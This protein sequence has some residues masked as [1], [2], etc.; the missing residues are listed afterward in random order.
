MSALLAVVRRDLLLAYRR[1]S[2]L[3]NP[4]VFFV[5][6]ITLFPL[7]VSPAPNT[8]SQM[9]PGVIWISALLATLL[10][11]ESLFRS[12]FDDGS[13]ELLLLTETPLPLIVM[14]KI[15]SHW[16]VSSLPLIILAPALSQL[17]YM[18]VEALGVLMLSLLLG[19]P[20][21]SLLGAVGVA[22]TVGLKRGG[23]LV[24]LL[25]LPLYIPILI[26]AVGAVQSATMGMD[27]GFQL[28]L[29]GAMFALAL[30]LSPFATAAALRISLS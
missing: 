17:L 30:T 13:L 8:L 12:D 10:S 11:L 19:T 26:F 18:P 1:R 16:L 3:M 7:A 25:V 20:I 2:E 5:I 29:L 14:G 27:S 28:Y 21:L 15:I 24:S 22:L 23:V 4:L 9:A 6:V